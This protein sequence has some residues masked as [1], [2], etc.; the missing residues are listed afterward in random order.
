MLKKILKRT[1]NILRYGLSEE[2]R[3]R[4]RAD[5]ALRA[6]LEQAVNALQT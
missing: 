1:R 5:K 3:V 6:Q 2:G 4:K